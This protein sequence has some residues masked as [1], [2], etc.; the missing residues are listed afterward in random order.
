MERKLRKSRKG[1]ADPE[2]IEKLKRMMVNNPAE[3]EEGTSGTARRCRMHKNALTRM[4][5]MA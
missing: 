5:R 1:V 3:G 4:Q 2:R